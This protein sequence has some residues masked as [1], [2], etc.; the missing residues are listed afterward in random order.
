MSR[1][2]LDD[3][4]GWPAMATSQR[5]ATTAGAAFAVH[6]DAALGAALERAHRTHPHR[7]VVAGWTHA[8]PAQHVARYGSRPPLLPFQSALAKCAFHYVRCV[9]N[10]FALP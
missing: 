5:A 9:L 3:D 6:T 2:T 7:Y 8:L 1:A 10:C 4:A